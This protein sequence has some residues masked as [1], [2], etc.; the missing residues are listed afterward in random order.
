[1]LAGRG[2]A[3]DVRA[4]DGLP[5]GRGSVAAARQ[6]VGALLDNAVTHGTA[7]VTLAL[8]DAGGTLAVDVA[9][10]GSGP[11]DPELMF[12]RRADG[13]PRHGIGLS[14]ARSLAE[15]EGGRL[16]LSRPR[17]PVFTLLLPAA[18]DPP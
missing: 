18:P 1:M 4:E 11:G 3:L 7:T 6:V 2:R 14:L 15:A 9:D 5:A 12:R 13:A 8:R 10:E 17:P 16:V